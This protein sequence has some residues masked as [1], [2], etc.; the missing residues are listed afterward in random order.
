MPTDVASLQAEQIEDPE[1]LRAKLLEAKVAYE[2]VLRIAEKQPVDR[3]LLSLSCVA[4]GKIFEFYDE[5]GM[6]IALY[7]KAIALSNISGGAY[8]EAIARKQKLVQQ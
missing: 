5:D 8:A 6:A 2:N 7:D 3:A 1:K 4:L